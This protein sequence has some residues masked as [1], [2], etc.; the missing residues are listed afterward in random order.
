MTTFDYFVLLLTSFIT[1]A[2]MTLAFGKTT[3]N[4]L[5]INYKS[6]IFL[7]IGGL[8]ITYN[9]YF[10][11]TILRI[12]MVLL[13]LIIVGYFSY[14]ESLSKTIINTLVCYL[15]MMFYEVIIS[16]FVSLFNIIDINSFNNSVI[17]K[18]LFSIVNVFLVYIS[19][20]SKIILNLLKKINSKI[21]DN[22][23]I[24]IMF[25]LIITILVSL[26]FKYS[27][28]FSN[29]IYL[30]NIIIIICLF[31]LIFI[32][33]YNYIKAKNEMEKSEILLNFMS[34]Y[35]KIIDEDRINR[36]EMLNNLLFLKSI[37]DKNSDEFNE[38]INELI[39]IYDKK[40]IGI[41]NIYKLPSGLKGIF[42][43]KLYGLQKDGYNININISKQISNSLKKVDYKDYVIVYKMIGILLDNAIEAA[44]KTK[45][46]IINIDIYNEDNNI[47][48]I[49]D[50]T[51]K[52]K[53]DKYKINEKNYTTKGKNRGLGLYIIKNLISNSDS[54][55][56]EQSILNNIFTSKIII[57]KKKN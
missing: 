52:G 19:M 25:S 1:I 23:I 4:K 39:T 32:C 48:I 14:K 56:F 17:F 11:I 9:A 34:K 6:I 41:K 7:L 49:I 5:K 53:I 8:L 36:H 30:T 26:D 35:E 57:N 3:N 51:F 47:I 45:D 33:L 29:K 21:S 44:K 2:I 24:F 27:V 18:L 22:K 43:Y 37:D 20:N 13:V 15:I 12:V 54:I 50:N 28:T 16:I 31:V 55:K 46:K 10:T 38:A 42:Y 40:G